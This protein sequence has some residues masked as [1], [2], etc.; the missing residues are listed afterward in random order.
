[1]ERQ[2][3]ATKNDSELE[4]RIA[5]ILMGFEPTGR[6]GPL[7]PLTAELMSREIVSAISSKT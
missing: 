1:M 5:E 2:A 7:H 4:N 6:E 3:G